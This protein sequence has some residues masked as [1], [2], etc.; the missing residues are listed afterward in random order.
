MCAALYGV[1]FGLIR[2][3]CEIM[4]IDYVCKLNHCY[5]YDCVI[6]CTITLGISLQVNNI[7]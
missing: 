1:I 5:F 4:N 7:K 2:C 3:V 6:T